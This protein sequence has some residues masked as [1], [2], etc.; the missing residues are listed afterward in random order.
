MD[1]TIREI[2]TSL[3]LKLIYLLDWTNETVKTY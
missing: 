3:I 2:H 1:P